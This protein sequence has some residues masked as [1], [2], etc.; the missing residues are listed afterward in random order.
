MS[1]ASPEGA[2]A[3]PRTEPDA[4]DATVVMAVPTAAAA[5]WG[6]PRRSPSSD[7]RRRSR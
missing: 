5:R 4:T 6:R 7:P 2:E 3:E 1:D